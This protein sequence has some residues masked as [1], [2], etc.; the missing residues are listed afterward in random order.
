MFP[1]V[2]CFSQG[3]CCWILDLNMVMLQLE[4]KLELATG[5]VD[6]GRTSFECQLCKCKK[7]S[8]SP[9]S[10][11]LISVALRSQLQEATNV[12]SL[13]RLSLVHSLESRVYNIQC[14]MYSVH[15]QRDQ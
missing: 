1:R 11:F 7:E 3:Q 2:L 8:R 15:Y 5:F 6:R 12:K 10:F 14:T 4:P 13:T 9:F